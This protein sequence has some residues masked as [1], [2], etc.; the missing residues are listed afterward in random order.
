MSIKCSYEKRYNYGKEKESEVLPKIKQ[1]FKDDTIIQSEKRYE[2]YDYKGLKLYELKSRDCG[3]NSYP[4]T[5]IPVDK[6]IK[7]II[8]L[9]NFNDGLYYIEYDETNFSKYEQKRFTLYQQNKMYYYIPNN[10]LIK[11]E[12]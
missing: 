5:M 1:F 7:D 4:T 3:L 11:I 8:L 12:I 6:C 2:K 9:F 10:D